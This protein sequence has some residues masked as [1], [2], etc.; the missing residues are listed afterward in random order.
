[1]RSFSDVVEVAVQVVFIVRAIISSFRANEVSVI[2][3]NK[4]NADISTTALR[5][6]LSQFVMRKVNLRLEPELVKPTQSFF[7]SN[8]TFF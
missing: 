6:F 7:D 3:L 2:L 1:M 8:L 4:A 5:C